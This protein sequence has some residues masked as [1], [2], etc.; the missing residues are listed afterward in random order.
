MPRAMVTADY[1]VTVIPIKL[2][3][4]IVETKPFRFL[5]I[6]FGLLDLADHSIIH[7]SLLYVCR[8]KNTRANQNYN[9][10]IFTFYIVA[11]APSIH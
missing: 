9:T 11:G 4:E 7:E 6:S 5:S 3:S 10:C 1:V 8:I 2:Y